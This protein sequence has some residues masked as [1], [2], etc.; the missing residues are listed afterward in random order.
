MVNT[1]RSSRLSQNNNNNNIIHDDDDDTEIDENENHNIKYN[2]QDFNQ[3]TTTTISKSKSIRNINSSSIPQSLSLSLS[4]VGP[5]DPIEVQINLQIF[6]V[7]KIDSSSEEFTIDCGISFKW[8]DPCL[9]D[10]LNG[11]SASSHPAIVR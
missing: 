9:I 4:T 11:I 3:S 8:T 1:R 2:N 5:R 6:R 7:H 10:K